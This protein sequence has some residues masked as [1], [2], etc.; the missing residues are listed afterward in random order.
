MAQ[1]PI[2]VRIGVAKAVSADAELRDR[3]ALNDR[4][5]LD[6]EQTQETQAVLY[7]NSCA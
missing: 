5:T 1:D 2:R 3:N 4:R 6:D 7:R